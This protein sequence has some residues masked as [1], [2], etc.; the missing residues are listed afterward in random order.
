MVKSI[1]VAKEL[2]L[3][4]DTELLEIPSISSVCIEYKYRFIAYH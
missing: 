1:G 3:R 2:T 4:V